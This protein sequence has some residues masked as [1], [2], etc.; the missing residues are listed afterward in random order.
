MYISTYLTLDTALSGVEAA[1]EELDTTG[2]NISNANTPDYEEQIVNLTEST[3]LSIS[4]SAAD[5]AMQLGE[6]VTTA[7]I[8]NSAQP[9]LDSAWRQTNAN[10]T[11]ASTTQGYLNQIQDALGSTSNNT[12]IQSE[13]ATFWSDWNTLTDNPTSAAAQQTVVND[14]ET[15]AQSLNSLSQDLNGSNPLQPADGVNN[16]S[17]LGQVNTQ[18][19]EIMGGPTGPGASGGTLYNDAYQISSLNDAI[20]Q[21]QAAGQNANNLIDQRNQALDSLS[22]LGNVQLQDNSDGSVSVFFGGVT[23]AGN[24][25]VGDPATAT[26]VSGI[27]LGDNFGAY[28]TSGGAAASGWVAAFQQQYE[29]SGAAGDTAAQLAAKVGGT[30]GSLIGLAGYSYTAASAGPPAVAASGAFGN[31][32]TPV[33]NASGDTTYPTPVVATE[34]GTIGNI[35]ASL[36]N[37][38]TTLMNEVNNPAVAYSGAAV[39]TATGV[40][41]VSG[42]G[43]SGAISLAAKFFVLNSSPDTNDAAATLAVSS[44]LQAAAASGI[45]PGKFTAGTTAPAPDNGV[46]NLQVSTL[47]TGYA[48]NYSS[49]N[50]VALDESQNAGGNADAAYASLVQQVGSLTRGANNAVSTQSALQTQVTS[51]RESAEGVDLSQEM[52]NLITEQ[53]AYQA[54]A[55]VMNAFSTVM[56]SLLTVVGQ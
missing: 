37:V 7:G 25:L 9:Y 2:Q 4:G 33:T 49:D 24:E 56:N 13:L 1:Q 23:G 31:L 18:Y 35:N 51:Q 12:G 41:P 46:S 30:L 53:Q 20:V 15:L 26:A 27:P 17:V 38:A 21:A 16:A 39:E 29:T 45:T 8:R 32:G 42:T 28:A 47:Y 40:A 14:G 48:G 34:L 6:G 5:G 52:A 55:R 44:S 19:E 36:N 22:S 3:S 50:D 11:A 54:S 43:T 10:A